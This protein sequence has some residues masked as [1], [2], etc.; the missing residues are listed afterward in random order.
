MAGTIEFAG[1]SSESLGVRIGSINVYGAPVRQNQSYTVPGRIGEL[2]DDGAPESIG[3]ELRRYD[4]A[5]FLPAGSTP[6][7]LEVRMTQIRQWLMGARGYQRL[8]DS[9]EP[10]YYREA[11]LAEDP[12]PARIGNS[13]A[14]GFSLAFSCRPQRFLKSWENRP[15]QIGIKEAQQITSIT[16]TNPTKQRAWPLIEIQGGRTSRPQALRFYTDADSN[17]LRGSL[18]FGTTG[19]HTIVLD[20]ETTEAWYKDD[21]ATSANDRITYIEG[22]ISLQPGITTIILDKLSVDVDWCEIY[23]RYWER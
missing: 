20:T 16:A 5:V 19:G 15:Y 9:Y 4:A 12:S 18:W 23:P 17:Q 2:L 1:I 10:D 8:T 7:L 13:E 21:P 11:V 3:N 6:Q 22:D 14:M